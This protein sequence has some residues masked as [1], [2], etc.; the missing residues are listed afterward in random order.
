VPYLYGAEI[1]NP[2]WRFA[3]GVLAQLSSI[4]WGPVLDW[5]V[6]V[7]PTIL[8]VAAVII[9]TLSLESRRSRI[10]W[11][12]VLLAFG[13]LISVIAW[14]Q[15]AFPYGAEIK[16]ALLRFAAA[17]FAQLSRIEWRP[18]LD[19]AVVVLPII[20]AVAAIILS[21]LSLESR[22]SRISWRLAVLALGAIIS[23]I[24][25]KQQAL[26]RQ[27]PPQPEASLLFVDPD[28]PALIIIN[29][30]DKVARQIIWTVA[31]WNL[32]DPRAYSPGPHSPDSH[33][34]LPIPVS[35]FDFLNPHQKADQ[36]TFFRSPLVAPYVKKGD[37]LFGSAS[38]RCSDCSRGHTYFVFI[39]FGHG[40][41]YSEVQSEKSGGAILPRSFTVS[42]V[43][44]YFEKT[45]EQIP[46][47]QRLEI[48]TWP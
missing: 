34:P 14:K 26:V 19:W 15:Q 13:A 47:S 7:L 4:E 38:V 21:T 11:R 8:A 10:S 31:L 16:N 22:R 17:I 39:I 35:K 32:D 25:W 37:K 23:V 41:W 33:E 5:A 42:G 24:A 40:G 44:N 12:L 36:E 48:K 45:M 46:E 6:V 2:V 9:S 3:A 28:M 18:I 43:K 30:T 20:L 29:D 1:N 27:P